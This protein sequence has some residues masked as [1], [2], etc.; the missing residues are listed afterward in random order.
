MVLPTIVP[1]LLAEPS[2]NLISGVDEI[3]DG[4]IYVRIKFNT[5]YQTLIS[6]YY[7]EWCWMNPE[8][9]V[10]DLLTNVPLTHHF[11]NFYSHWLISFRVSTKLDAD[12]IDA[13]FVVVVDEL[14]HPDKCDKVDSDSSL[15]LVRISPV[16]SPAPIFRSSALSNNSRKILSLLL[17]LFDE[18][19]T[20]L[21]DCTVMPCC[22]ELLPPIVELDDENICGCDEIIVICC[23]LPFAA[24]VLIII[25]IDEVK[26]TDV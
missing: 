26:G 12:P 15:L 23:G 2:G 6:D 1:Q 8:A 5:T 3:I 22:T 21:D 9:D 13:V 25:D 20:E 10:A 17:L 19:C 18:C 11:V 7:Q 4:G 16:K 24:L 14:L